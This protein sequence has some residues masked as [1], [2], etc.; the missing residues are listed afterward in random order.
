MVEDSLRHGCEGLV[1]G[2]G[3]AHTP[4]RPGNQH[5]PSLNPASFIHPSIHP[6]IISGLSALLF[7]LASPPKLSS[8]FHL[9]HSSFRCGPQQSPCAQPPSSSTSCDQLG[10]KSAPKQGC[11]VM[12]RSLMFH[13]AGAQHAVDSADDS[14]K[15]PG[16]VLHE[17]EPTMVRRVHGAD[18]GCQGIAI[19]SCKLSCPRLLESLLGN[20]HTTAANTNTYTYT[21]TNTNTNA[22]SL[23]STQNSRIRL[24][25]MIMTTTTT[26]MMMTTTTTTGTR[27]RGETTPCL[28]PKP[29]T[30]KP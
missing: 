12:S 25:R 13:R 17:R 4:G 26:M 19:I 28:N 11:V 16:G 3:P 22:L 29:Q 2:G 23:T 10:E 8:W 1:Q 30:L 7:S 21:N 24:K 5:P 14:H 18:D 15:S 9:H 6:S 27:G 20:R